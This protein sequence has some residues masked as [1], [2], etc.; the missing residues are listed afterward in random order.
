L[1]AKETERRLEEDPGSYKQFELTGIMIHATDKH[2]L[3]SGRA[4]GNIGGE[5]KMAVNYTLGTANLKPYIPDS[6]NRIKGKN[7]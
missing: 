7:N 3:L 6:K 5:M 4:T 2:E 1:A